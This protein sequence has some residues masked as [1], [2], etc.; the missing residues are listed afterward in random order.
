MATYYVDPSINANSGTG[1]VGDPFGDLQYAFNQTTRGSGNRFNIKAGTAEVLAASLDLTTYGSPDYDYPLIL[2]GYT[3]VENDGGI[4]EI[5]CNGYSMWAASYSAMN[6]VDLELHSFGDNNGVTLGAYSFMNNCEVHKGASSP[7]GKSLVSGSEIGL[8]GCY[9]HDAGAGA[10]RCFYAGAFSTGV[11]GCYMVLGAEAVGGAGMYF[12]STGPSCIGNIVVCSHVQQY[13]IWL[14]NRGSA[15]G[16][17]V[18]ST[19]AGT[20]AGITNGAVSSSYAI[21]NIVVGFSGVGGHGLSWTIRS[22][23]GHNAFYNCTNPSSTW[24]YI[25]IGGDIILGADPFTNAAAG[26]FS[27]TEAAKAALAGKGF[28]LTYFGAHASTVPNLNIGPIQMAAAAGGGGGFPIL[29]GSVV[30]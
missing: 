19:V 14:G 6:L 23:R 28:P 2:R 21:N 30:R 5:N 17:I 27:L 1:T 20:Y 13:G 8:V 25:D 7:S 26:D 4:A 12:G 29:G 16:N 3:S 22:L 9:I 15:I 11:Y 10:A 24:S 18:Y